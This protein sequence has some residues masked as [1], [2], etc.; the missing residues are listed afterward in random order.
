M[1]VDF[2]SLQPNQRYFAMVQSIVPRPIAWV[3]SD[4]GDQR[5][6]LAPY[7]FFTGVCSDPPLL[8]IS[9]GKK[10]E[11]KETGEAKDT[12]RNILERKHFVVHIASTPSLNMLNA[13][14]ATLDHDES[15]ISKLG[16]LTEDFEGFSLPRLKDSPIAFGCELYRVDEIG[17]T[18]QAVIYGEIKSMFID[19]AIID[20]HPSRLV[21]NAE[22]LDPL[23]RLGGNF[24]SSLG[25]QLVAE[26]PD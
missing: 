15:E 3:L 26:R 21:I 14:A 16:L 11:G 18:P 1:L 9:A 13:S 10:P 17:N 24:Y 8:M 12:R 25:E 5:L 20:A 22:R 6:N 23:A 2:T 4:S 7:S 19:D